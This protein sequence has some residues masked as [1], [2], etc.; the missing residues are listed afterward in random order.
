MGLRGRIEG[1]FETYGHWV[2]RHAWLLLL[3]S[4]AV[5]VA[6]AP[7]LGALKTDI[8]F[9]SFLHPDDPV[10]FE[11]EVF[12]DR[13]GREDAVVVLVEA[14]DVFARSFLDR[15]YALHAGALELPHV[16]DV[17]SLVNVRDTRG[18]GDTLLVG[19][20][21][22]GWPLDEG[23][24]RA[25]RARALAN[26]LFVH[27]VISA[28]A[29]FTSVRIDLDT[30]STID[31]VEEDVLAGFGDSEAGSATF[32]T[33]AET[34]AFVVALHRLLD[35]WRA[36]GFELHAAGL[37]VMLHDISQA[38]Q[39]DMKRFVGASVL[40]IALLLFA[41]F[42]SP[43]G[44]LLPIGVVGLS[45][46]STLGLMG[47]LGSPIHLPTQILPSMLLAIGVADAVHI[48][49]IFFREL[50]Q[51]ASRDQALTRALG[52]SAL[53][54]V[55]T[56][57]TTSGG[58]VSF[59]YASI[60]PVAALG[61]YAP[62]GVLFA[63]F[64]SL[65]LLPAL[66]AIIPIGPVS[67]GPAYGARLERLLT[68]T[69]A[70]ATRHPR[71]VMAAVAALCLVAAAGLPRIEFSHDPPVWLQQ[72]HPTRRAIDL[73]D[74]D[75]GGAMT[76]ELQVAGK[77]EGSLRSPGLLA[78]MARLGELLET[79]EHSGLTAG[80]TVSLADV[81]KEIHRA[82]N[83]GRDSHY[84]V[85]ESEALIAQ[86]LLLFE[87]SGTDDLEELVDTSYSLGRI[88]VRLPW[89]DGIRYV[90]FLDAINERAAGVLTDAQEITLAGNLPIVTRTVRAV[91]FGVF[92]SYG[93]ALL[94]IVP[95]MMLLLGS[96]RLGVYAMVPNLVPLLLTLGWMGWFAVP[97]DA[98]TMMTGGIALGLVVDDTI[99]V[100]HNFARYHARDGDVGR[101]IEET[102]A[103]VGRAITI[104]SVVLG[105][106][107]LIFTLSSMANL[108]AFGQVLALAVILALA[109]DVLV[110]PALLTLVVRDFDS[111]EELPGR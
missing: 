22:E 17:T 45:V 94:I 11:Y 40:T 90:P 12:R 34:D 79:E 110:V 26:P 31:H 92:E 111:T 75:M 8:S 98:F 6:L 88:S 47:H 29:R 1:G 28:D 20:L 14:E 71:S 15:L 104:T 43:V 2:A 102:L 89:H 18:D 9:E 108:V 99:H 73:V 16:E 57:L 38:M 85:P 69:G 3:A 70:F 53:P 86:E 44:V 72:G 39:R 81:V 58:L 10:R 82:L 41:I 101:A 4:L 13:F 49:A 30:Y 33:T 48:L 74:R 80:Q 83:E 63:L 36:P 93:I 84:V 91:I 51:D 52:H 100:M 65:T 35:E 62:I 76:V 50:E 106:G 60:A 59:A 5:A 61:F 19:D 55:L 68:S 32:L 56:S 21:L 25:A 103:G 107:F 23:G 97:F 42:R 78:D 67:S 46:I 7:G 96:F 95:L 54:V 66:L 24:R 105:S 37:S 64:Y 27:N 109:A 87:S 77:G